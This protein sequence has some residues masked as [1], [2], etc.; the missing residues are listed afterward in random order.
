MKATDMEDDS[1]PL[2]QSAFWAEFHDRIDREWY[3]RRERGSRLIWMMAGA[4]LFVD[5]LIFCTYALEGGHWWLW[6]GM[7]VPLVTVGVMASRV[8][9]AAERDGERLA[10]H[11]AL[12]RPWMKHT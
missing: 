2:E 9:D 8:L 6:F 10:E 12:E 4:L 11:D 7:L 1:T 3:A 5:A